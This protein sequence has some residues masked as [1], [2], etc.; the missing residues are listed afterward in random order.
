MN[1]QKL[2]SLLKFITLSIFTAF[3]FWQ[4]EN[5]SLINEN[6]NK[7]SSVEVIDASMA[8][9]EIFGS[10]KNQKKA[11]SIF[12]EI[13][14]NKKAKKLTLKSQSITYTF[15]LKNE[16]LN[17]GNRN[18]TY[19]VENL[20]V[21]LN[22][23][24]SYSTYIFRYTPNMPWFNNPN[25]DIRSYT[26]GIE[27]L[28]TDR[29]I[30]D[31]FSLISGEPSENN[32]SSNRTYS[33]SSGGCQIQL[34]EICTSLTHG[35][36]SNSGFECQITISYSCSDGG[37]NGEGGSNDGGGEE[38]SGDGGSNGSGDSTSTN[39]IIGT[40]E[41]TNTCEED[42]IIIFEPE[43]PIENVTEFLECLDTNQGAEITVYVTEPNP[44]S[45]DTH[46]GT[47]VGHTFVSISQ[48]SNAN[49]FGFYPVSSNIYPLVNPSSDSTLG[50]DGVA[51]EPYT[52]S[53]STT[54]S[55]SQLQQIIDLSI[56]HN[57]TYHLDNYNCTDFAI[58][59]GNLGGLN[60]PP[61]NG[62][63]PGGRGSNPGTLGLHIKNLQSLPS[64]VT[65]E[66]NEGNAQLTEQ[67]C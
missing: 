36:G 15:A 4:C 47:F 38:S 58:D 40:C 46:S 26:G 37:S 10:S 56:N 33:R 32:I 55:A 28:D 65:T 16:A 44:G 18:S 49:T 5:E 25:N 29:Q 42:E 57:P 24:G 1:K 60:L 6:N 27:L 43:N 66:T 3:L 59:I 34:E 63:W 9:N 14:F 7:E 11:S 61:S 41:E 12:S 13:D 54:V 23:D 20:S 67:G 30:L 62:T 52:A 19:T 35:D 53:I 2:K 22:T 51:P 50:N 39:P 8:L 48:G 64:G 45:G 17:K 21:K 31:T